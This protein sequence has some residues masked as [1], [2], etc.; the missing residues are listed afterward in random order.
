[1]P[2]KQEQSRYEKYLERGVAIVIP[3]LTLTYLFE[4]LMRIGPCIYSSMGQEPLNWTDLESWQNQ[5]GITLSPFE[6]SIIRKASVIYVEQIQLSKKPD[7]VPPV[8]MVEQE[9]EKF[10]NHIKSILR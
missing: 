8:K 6:L 4:Y 1:M 9:T 2:D 5:H 7:C 10:V 3:E